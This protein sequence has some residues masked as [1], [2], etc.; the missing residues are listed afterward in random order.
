MIAEKELG[1]PSAYILFCPALKSSIIYHSF[2]FGIASLISE[3]GMLP[4]PQRSKKEIMIGRY[5][6]C[7]G[8]RMGKRLGLREDGKSALLDFLSQKFIFGLGF[9][10]SC[11]DRK[12]MI[13]KNKERRLGRINPYYQSKPIPIPDISVSLQNQSL[14][15]YPNKHQSVKLEKAPLVMQRR[16]Y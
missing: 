12:K 16:V 14:F 3:G 4:K 1:V 10:P 6:R 9:K 2:E 13:E 15:C 8:F 7:R 11:K 5:F